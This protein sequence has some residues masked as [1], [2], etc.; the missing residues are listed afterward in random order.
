MWIW[1]L[2]AAAL[3]YAASRVALGYPRP[4]QRFHS[5]FRHEVAF[6]TGAAEATFP[7]GGEI[8]PSGLEA[9]VPAY[10][11]QLLTASH[12]RM[13]LMMHLL[14]F[15]VEHG[16][17]FFPVPGPRGWR[18]FSALAADQRAAALEGWR[19]SRL[20]PRRLVFASL[21]AI[22]TM[23]YFAFP[24]VLRQ[25]GLAPYEIRTPVV[26]ADLWYPRIGASRASLRLSPADLTPP[27]DGRP[28]PL[29]SPLHPAYRKRSAR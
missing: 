4:A 22:L 24:P 12:P 1:I 29:D 19:T 18:R 14:F 20:F 13:R 2:V 3:G 10:T 8:P 7:A 23:G 9:D 27:S 25:L 28:I 16:T 26:E 11:D 17:I 5:L 15:L 6:L 21:R